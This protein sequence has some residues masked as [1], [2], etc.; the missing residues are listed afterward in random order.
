MNRTQLILA[1]LLRSFIGENT[2]SGWES[3]ERWRYY[4]NPYFGTRVELPLQ[5]TSPRLTKRTT[6]PQSND[7][8]TATTTGTKKTPHSITKTQTLHRTTING[9]I[10]GCWSHVTVGETRGKATTTSLQIKQC[11]SRDDSPG[12]HEES[13]TS[14]DPQKTTI[15]AVPATWSLPNH[16]PDI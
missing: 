7:S 3:G 14:T 15:L 8:S 13:A 10:G 6:S 11:I 12:R 16:R 4:V 1:L 5:L 9:F 2:Q